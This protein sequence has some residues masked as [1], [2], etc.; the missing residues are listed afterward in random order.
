[1]KKNIIL[2]AILLSVVV[3]GSWDK[4]K[5]AATTS[6]KLS[7]PQMLANNAAI[8]AAID[9]DHDFATGG[10]Q[11]G[12]HNMVSLIETANLGT[13]A[14]GLPILGA[15][16]AGGKAELVFT[17][18]DDNDIQ[19]TSGGVIPSTS[20]DMLDEDDMSSDDPN[21]TASQQSVKAYVDSG[22]VTMTNKTLTSAVLNTG[23]SGTAVLDEDDMSSD[24]ATQVA[25]QQSI[26]AYVDTKHTAAGTVQ[27]DGN[28]VFNTTMTSANVWQDLDL[29]A[30][31]G[32][33]LALCFFEVSSVNGP[34][35]LIKQ[36]GSGG[37]V[38]EHQHTE[39][40][41]EVVDFDGGET[42][43]SFVMMMT[44]SSG[45]VQIAA[46]NITDTITIKLLNF[47]R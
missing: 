20:T 35:V 1:M 9:Q 31:V 21:K 30:Y 19:I 43:R 4:T 46:E 5:P 38:A 17:D 8:E 32:S 11:T 2:I 33:N 45:I 29:S 37:T 13:G 39:N 12:K 24:S 27:S 34:I 6:L 16:T 47:I 23:V 3:Y 14:E 15:Q 40:G 18:E 36:K 41:L 25:T 44:D 7:N 26:K 42:G 10:T 22:T 28:I